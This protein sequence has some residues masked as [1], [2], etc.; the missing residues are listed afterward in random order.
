ME[1]MSL[2]SWLAPRLAALCEDAL[3]L[4]EP[5]RLASAAA[6]EVLSG[7]RGPRRSQFSYVFMSKVSKIVAPAELLVQEL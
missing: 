3:R 4:E 1:T 6:C 2:A 7:A 5:E